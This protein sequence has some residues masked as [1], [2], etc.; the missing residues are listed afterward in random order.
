MKIFDYEEVVMNWDSFTYPIAV[1]TPVSIDGVLADNASAHGLIAR[2]VFAKPDADETL[3]VMTGGIID[4]EEIVAGYGQELSSAAVNALC[5]I[6]FYKNGK[7]ISAGGGGGDDSQKWKEETSTQLFSETVTTTSRYGTVNA[8]LTYSEPITADTLIVTFN[9]VEYT[10]NKKASGDFSKYGGMDE[11]SN[12]DFS[13][14]PFALSCDAWGSNTLYTE[15]PGTYTISVVEPIVDYSDKFINGVIKF[16]GAKLVDSPSEA[17]VVIL[18]P[19][20]GEYVEF[21]GVSFLNL[22]AGNTPTRTSE[23]VGVY[24]TQ[25]LY[26][27]SVN[28]SISYDIFVNPQNM[29]TY[30]GNESMVYLE[31]MVTESGATWKLRGVSSQI[32]I[33]NHYVPYFYSLG[34]PHK[35]ESVEIT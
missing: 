29:L 34:L 3:K 31:S 30:L 9:G 25:I 8:Y 26:R 32:D 5:G 13:V 12:L 1:G 21:T 16:S 6:H 7:C 15:T 17:D 33:T 28:Q 4:M 35:I 22:T 14:Y 23:T 11:H 24:N 20:N 27:T 18:V 2:T 19:L 10:V